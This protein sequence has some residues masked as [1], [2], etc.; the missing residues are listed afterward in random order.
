MVAVFPSKFHLTSVHTQLAYIGSDLNG[1]QDQTWV[2]N[3]LS[4]VQAVGG[5]LIVS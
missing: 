5:P 4:L 3:V 1:T 2:P